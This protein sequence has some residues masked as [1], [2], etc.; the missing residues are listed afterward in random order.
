MLENPCHS[1]SFL[2]Q[3]DETPSKEPHKMR[4]PDS[5]TGKIAIGLQTQYQELWYLAQ[6]KQF[7]VALNV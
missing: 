6:M 5:I 4:D 7:A 3:T 1:L 2:S